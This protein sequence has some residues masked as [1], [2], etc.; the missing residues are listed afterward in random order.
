MRRLIDVVRLRTRS[1][2][3]RRRADEE[4]DRELRAHLEYQIEEN[5]S[6][7]MSADDAR[8]AAISTFGGV[9]RIREEARDARGVSVMENLV[10]DLR[11]SLRGLRH[12]PMLLVAA[13]VSIALGV[14][15]NLAVFSLAREFVF[16]A[17]S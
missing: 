1:L 17:P 12:E 9:E 2:F 7:G 14:G 5:V 13:T 15:G 11:Y 8:R 4:L 3:R 10:R 6:R 16:A